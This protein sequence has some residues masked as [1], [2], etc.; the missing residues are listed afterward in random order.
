MRRFW[1][2]WLPLLMAGI[3]AGCGGTSGIS[4]GVPANADSA[5]KPLDPGDGTVPDMKGGNP[6]DKI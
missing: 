2:L 6:I 4:P 5:P 1:A 3:L